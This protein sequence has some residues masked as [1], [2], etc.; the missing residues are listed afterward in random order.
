MA[1]S[2]RIEAFRVASERFFAGSAWLLGATGPQAV[3]VQVLAA[4]TRFVIDRAEARWE[5]VL[6]RPIGL[7][8]SG[9]DVPAPAEVVEWFA[10]NPKHPELASQFAREIEDGD[11]EALQAAHRVLTEVLVFKR[12]LVRAYFADALAARDYRAIVD[13]YDAARAELDAVL[14]SPRAVS[15]L[16]EWY[17]GLTRAGPALD[18]AAAEVKLRAHW[19]AL[20]DAVIGAVA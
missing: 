20:L 8:S 6:D 11:W 19:Q 9:Y 7:P 10:I 1:E 2:R 3:V 13:G 15:V 17:N 18:E 16:R 5:D 14:E 4:L 12:P